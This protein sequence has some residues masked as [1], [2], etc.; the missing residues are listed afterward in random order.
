MFAVDARSRRSVPI[1]SRIFG[2]GEE[3]RLSGRPER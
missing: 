2:D 1:A 3:E